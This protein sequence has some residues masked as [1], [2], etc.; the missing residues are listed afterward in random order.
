DDVPPVVLA[1]LH[2]RADLLAHDGA[3]AVGADHEVCVP[4]AARRGRDRHA[5]L[6]RV[7]VADLLLPREVDAA[8]D[9]PCEQVGLDL[10]LRE[11]REV[12]VAARGRVGIGLG[13]DL[14]AREE[15]PLGVPVDAVLVELCPEPRADAVEDL[16]GLGVR[17]DRAA[18]GTLTALTSRLEDDHRQPVGTQ[19]ERGRETHGTRA[20]DDHRLAG[21]QCSFLA[22]TTRASRASGPRSVIRTGLR[23]TSVTSSCSTRSRPPARSTSTSAGRSTAGAPRKP[24][25]TRCGR[26]ST[27][28]AARSRESGAR[29]RTGSEP[30]SAA[31]PP[32]AS[33][34]TGPNTA[35]LV[36]PTMSSVPSPAISSS[37]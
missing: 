5:V 18:P 2:L 13:V 29:R 27:I 34:T 8:R 37:R 33:I 31:T 24:S 19:G 16:Q 25:R 17:E 3:R 4:L 14:L 28:S 20:D 11:A 36:P 6:V 15:G 22:A 12:R 1:A 21:H 26:A 30:S 32:I 35:S 9:R 7:H 23:W 10:H